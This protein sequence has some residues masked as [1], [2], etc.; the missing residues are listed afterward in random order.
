[1]V[2]IAEQKL[3]SRPTTPSEVDDLD[4]PQPWPWLEPV[5]E[6]IC[7]LSPKGLAGALE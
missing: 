7:G 6:V 5:G 1:M 3:L 4:E 2:E